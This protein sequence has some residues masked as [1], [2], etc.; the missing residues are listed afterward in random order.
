LDLYHSKLSLYGSVPACTWICN[1]TTLEVGSISERTI[2]GLKHRLKL[3]R[4]GQ[5][6]RFCELK[7]YRQVEWK[8]QHFKKK[9]IML[10]SIQRLITPVAQR[11]RNGHA[12][13]KRNELRG[14]YPLGSNIDFTVRDYRY[15]LSNSFHCNLL[16]KPRSSRVQLL[17]MRLFITFSIHVCTEHPSH[18]SSISAARSWLRQIVQKGIGSSMEEE[19]ERISDHFFLREARHELGCIERI[20]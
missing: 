13:P 18:S 20:S 11:P 9:L 19:F 8:R 5:S 6:K 15:E 17:Q 3:K 14:H 16:N 4:C 2:V 12:C 1:L 7:Q 10:G